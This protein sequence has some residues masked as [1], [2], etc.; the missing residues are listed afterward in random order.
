M[1]QE[2]TKKCYVVV[3]LSTVKPEYNHNYFIKPKKDNTQI[4]WTKA[5]YYFSDHPLKKYVTLV[6][7]FSLALT[8]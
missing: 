6:G 5:S 2:N 4:D 8:V 1:A 7:T 3:L